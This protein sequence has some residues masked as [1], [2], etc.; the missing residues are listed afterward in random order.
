[1]ATRW[2]A[3]TSAAFSSA[4]SFEFTNLA[5]GSLRV[6]TVTGLTT[7]TPYYV[8]VSA[9]NSIGLSDPQASSPASVMPAQ[10]PSA[11]TGVALHVTS[12]AELTVT[13]GAPAKRA[14]RPSPSTAW[15][16]TC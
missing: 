2:P 8:R 14:G 4:S 15:S 5:G 7:G 10:I 6:Y 9:H 16:G 11:P 13:F 3:T 1:M 12:Q